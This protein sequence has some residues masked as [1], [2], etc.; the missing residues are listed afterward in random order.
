MTIIQKLRARNIIARVAK[1]QGISTAECRDKM[2]AAITEAW[3]TTDPVIRQHQIQLV[4]EERIPTP[5][6]FV[7]LIS[8][9]LPKDFT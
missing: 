7:F 5:E 9:K 8:S 2:A 4:G 6:E 1:Q 3:R